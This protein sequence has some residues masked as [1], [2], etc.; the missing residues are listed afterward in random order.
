MET[1]WTVSLASPAQTQVCVSTYGPHST[2][3]LRTLSMPRSHT[4]IHSFWI[5]I[6]LP[7]KF[8]WSN[9][10]ICAGKT[11]EVTLE[12]SKNSIFHNTEKYSFVL[13]GNSY[14]V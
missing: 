4:F 8:S 9:S 5:S 7:W 1:I 6:I 2:M 13:K 12:G 3:I 11:W 10:M 14:I